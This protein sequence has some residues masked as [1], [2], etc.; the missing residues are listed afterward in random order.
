MSIVLSAY[1]QSAFCEFLLPAVN[2]ADT[3]IELQKG[4]FSLQEDVILHL[5][6][7]DKEWFLRETEKYTFSTQRVEQGADTKS[8]QGTRSGNGMPLKNGDIITVFEKNGGRISLI[9]RETE[10]AF[11]V[12]RKYDI[13]AFQ[14]LTV[15]NES[16]NQ[17][18]YRFQGLVSGHHAVLQRT[19]QGFC[20]QD[21]SSNGTFVNGRKVNG[22]AELQIGDCINIF[23][24]KIVYLGNLIAVHAP[25]ENDCVV[26]A[27]LPA[28]IQPNVPDR[29]DKKRAAAEKVFSPGAQG[30]Y[31]SGNRIH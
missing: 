13:S 25:A 16:D 5:E 15:G 18:V 14:S 28:Y 6:V 17:I 11:S 3:E 4:I 21:V 26:A 7:A 9:V 2:N 20:V 22:A 31:A 23:G 27:S 10:V 30:L 8:G 24:L 12:F 29:E 1:V 19:A